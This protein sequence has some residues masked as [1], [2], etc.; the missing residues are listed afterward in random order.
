MIKKLI[1]FIVLLTSAEF[2]TLFIFSEDTIKIVEAAVII[3]L[4]IA[5]LNK[6]LFFK[7]V[8]KHRY[9]DNFKKGVLLIL[10]GVFVSIM[11]AYLYHSQPPEITLVTQRAM[12]YYLLF[13]Y[14]YKYKIDEK[15]LK[16]II[17]VMATLYSAVY[18]GAL[19]NVNL[20]QPSIQAKVLE[21]RETTRLA[22]PGILYIIVAFFISLDKIVAE[23]KYLYFSFFLIFLANAITTGTRAVIF[24]LGILTMLYLMKSLRKGRL[25]ATTLVL[26]AIVLGGFYFYEILRSSYDLLIQAST[27]EE[28]NIQVR[29]ATASYFLEDFFPNNLTYVLGN[30][31]ASQLTDYGQEILYYKL[32]YGFYQ[33][34]IGIVGEY[35]SYGVFYLLGVIV[36]IYTILKN[37]KFIASK[38]ILYPFYYII[39]SMITTPH[40][41]IPSHI[42][43]I[44][45]LLY[46][47][48]KS[49][50][51]NQK[52]LIK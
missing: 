15:Y 9:T 51:A 29:L 34:D 12:Y 30:G 14:L 36:I 18:F 22:I 28:G 43:G 11:P 2:F 21:E 20:V 48:N 3:F 5:L 47:A 32:F 10:L 7:E 17:I 38:Y 4:F 40:F 45:L 31:L 35:I 23:K 26:A 1:T 19:I 33:S 25:L 46:L 49:I 42:T 8:N 13:F 24:S 6:V 27:L 16:K 39:I 37:R 52:Y 50:R 44:C 41:G